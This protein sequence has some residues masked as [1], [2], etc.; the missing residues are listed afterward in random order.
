MSELRKRGLLSSQNLIQG[1]V[2]AETVW[3]RGFRLAVERLV[4]SGSPK[5]SVNSSRKYPAINGSK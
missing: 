5:E 1:S 2:P 4:A 3:A